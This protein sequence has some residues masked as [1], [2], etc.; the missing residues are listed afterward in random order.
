M[1]NLE[2]AIIEGAK[3]AQ[4]EYSEMTN[5]W[6]SHGPEYFITCEVCKNI[7]KSNGY[8]V[9][10]EASP[11]KIKSEINLVKRG[12]NPKSDGERFDIVVWEKHTKNVRAII[13][14][15]RAYNIN[16]IRSD[17]EK[18]KKHTK[19]LDFVKSGYV[20]AYH[21]AKKIETLQNAFSR[22]SKELECELVGIITGPDFDN[23]CKWGFGLFKV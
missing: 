20:L 1:N 2:K 9:F 17:L 23:E 10:P 6:V 21:E 16:P 8:L 11:K 7:A 5:W 15:K 13:E 12:P 3:I 19:K 22:W 4:N 14:V 18:I